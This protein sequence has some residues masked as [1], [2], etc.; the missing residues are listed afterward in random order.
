MDRIKV[1][2]GVS[3]GEE[4]ERELRAYAPRIDLKD[5]GHLVGREIRL[6]RSD[7]GSPEQKQATAELDAAVQDAEVLLS[8][9]RLPENVPG[10]TPMLKW[11]QSMG[12]GVERILRSGLS[13]AGVIV[14]N[15]RGVASRPIAEWVL[16]SALMISKNMPVYF[17][18]K[19][20]RHYQRM[21]LRNFSLEGM[22][23]GILGV[24]AIGGEIAKLSKAFGMT[25]LATRKNTD[26]P[27]PPSVDRL[28]PPSGTGE[29]LETSDFV[30][31]SLPLT[32]ETAGSISE[33]QLRSMK[34]SA[35]IMNIGRGP[36]IDEAALVRALKE[37]WIAGAALDV[38]EKEPLPQ[39]SELWAMDNVILTPHISGEVEDYND[40][41]VAVFKENLGRYLAGEALLNVVDAERGY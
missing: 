41:V 37:G 15:A 21:D 23:M 32:P 19:R 25:V 2:L 35:Y 11:V 4:M 3:V 14:T 34:P 36:I 40:R 9:F 13:E 6:L 12:A 29:L 8:S 30:V 10:R 16:C 28:F 27:V 18:R 39:D 31:V 26:G 7:P 20:D 17:Q 22:S 33:P 1:A 5:V 24:G 38:F